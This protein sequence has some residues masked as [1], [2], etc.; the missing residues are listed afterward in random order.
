MED[1]FAAPAELLRAMHVH[2]NTPC[3]P[4]CLLP[5]AAL[6]RSGILIDACQLGPGQSSF[7]QQAAYLTGGTY[8]KPAR[9]QALV[10]YLNVSEQPAAAVGCAVQSQPCVCHLAGSN[11]GAPLLASP[12]AFSL[13]SPL[14]LLLL[15][16]PAGH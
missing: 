10:Q 14:P 9:P 15:S 4:A 16:E 6:Q 5:A 7:L 11:A 13:C 12:S 2:H 3:L 1:A 8:L